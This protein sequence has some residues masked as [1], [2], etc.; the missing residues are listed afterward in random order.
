MFFTNLTSNY[1]NRLTLPTSVY[2]LSD[3]QWK[4]YRAKQLKAEIAELD[5]LIDGHRA[6]ISRLEAT[7]QELKDAIPE[8]SPSDS[9]DKLPQEQSQ[10]ELSQGS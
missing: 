9:A 4:A 5:K 1:A 2:V 3:S 7:K 10:S 8:V 6:S